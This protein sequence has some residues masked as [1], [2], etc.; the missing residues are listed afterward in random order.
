MSCLSNLKHFLSLIM[1][2]TF[3][4]RWWS[5]VG[6]LMNY[7]LRSW[8]RIY[9]KIKRNQIWFKFWNLIRRQ[10]FTNYCI[11]VFGI[12]CHKT[13]K[14]KNLCRH[15]L[16]SLRLLKCHFFPRIKWECQNLTWQGYKILFGQLI[17]RLKTRYNTLI[18]PHLSRIIHIS[19]SHYNQARE[20]TWVRWMKN[21]TNVLIRL[22]RLRKL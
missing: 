6:K 19:T 16:N 8:S 15:N 21:V 9:K 1:T 18:L 11:N 10:I 20:R 3:I 17:L 5:S 4:C 13:V 14:T 2:L 22:R 12:S 7:L